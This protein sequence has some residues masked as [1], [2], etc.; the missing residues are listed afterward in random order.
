MLERTHLNLSRTSVTLCVPHRNEA[1]AGD[2]VRRRL[3]RLAEAFGRKAEVATF[4]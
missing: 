1:L 4:V 3:Q 2:A